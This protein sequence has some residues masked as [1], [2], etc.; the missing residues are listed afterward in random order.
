MIRNS[1]RGWGFVSRAFHW[2][3]ALLI[4]GMLGLGFYMVRIEMDL[5]NQYNEIQ[6]HK[7]FGVSVFA[8][9]FFRLAWRKLSPD[10]P[11]L[12]G[13]TPA[14]QVKAAR[15]SH[16]ALYV[17]MF[18]LPITG[19]LMASASPLNDV[20][21]FPF[22]IRN[23]VFDLFELPDPFPKGSQFLRDALKIIHLAAALALAA[24]LLVHTLA[25][26]KHHFVDGDNVLRRMLIGR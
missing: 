14:W 12:P 25:A 8:L 9:A 11:S 2:L 23:T 24:V 10:H 18:T 20:D 26:F 13:D 21:A 6:W 1:K 22:Q 3:M 7:S 16:I 19:W 4:L 5:V 15:Y 17:L